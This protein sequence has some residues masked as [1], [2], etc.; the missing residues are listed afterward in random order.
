MSVCVGAAVGLAGK[1]SF[2]GSRPSEGD[3]AA[4]GSVVGVSVAS[5]AVRVSSS[6]AEKGDR[7]GQESDERERLSFSS[8]TRRSISAWL[9]VCERTSWT[10]RVVCTARRRKRTAAFFIEAGQANVF[11]GGW[12]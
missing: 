11:A 6:S 2:A 12:V 3:G 9:R 7:F 5:S 8:R 1:G 10:L 4:V